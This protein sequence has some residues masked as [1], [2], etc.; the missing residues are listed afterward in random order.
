MV[1]AGWV[2]DGGG[3]V[4]GWLFGLVELLQ[5]ASSKPAVAATP[6]MRTSEVTSS[7]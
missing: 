1:G 7:R 6:T 3:D 5:A 4:V 2:D